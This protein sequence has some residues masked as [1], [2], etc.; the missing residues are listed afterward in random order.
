MLIHKLTLLNQN[1][2]S[3]SSKSGESD[4]NKE[5]QAPRPYVHCCG[6]EF[7]TNILTKLLIFAYKK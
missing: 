5:A 6:F 2:S 1:I 3:I 7:L 4:D